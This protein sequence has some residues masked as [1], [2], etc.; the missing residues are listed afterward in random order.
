MLLWQG[1]ANVTGHVCCGVSRTLCYAGVQ[2][3]FRG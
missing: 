1:H 3:D 2:Y